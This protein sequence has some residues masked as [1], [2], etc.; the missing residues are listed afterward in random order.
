M[1]AAK[2]I[3]RRTIV[4]SYITAGSA[5]T[6]VILGRREEQGRIESIDVLAVVILYPPIKGDGNLDDPI[7]ELEERDCGYGRRRPDVQ[8]ELA[9]G[10]G[11]GKAIRRCQ[12]E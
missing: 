4:A 2:E 6:R 11:H 8:K 1:V 3:R 7:N 9:L 12:A 10:Q 5:C